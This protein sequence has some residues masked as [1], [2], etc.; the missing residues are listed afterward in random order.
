MSVI[1]ILR[2]LRKENHKFEARLDYTVSSR[3]A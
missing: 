3:I 1:P 2:K